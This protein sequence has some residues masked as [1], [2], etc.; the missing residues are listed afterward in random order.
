[1]MRCMTAKHEILRRILHELTYEW[2]MIMHRFLFFE[3]TEKL[4][5]SKNTTEIGRF[6]LYTLLDWAYRQKFI[7]PSIVRTMFNLTGSGEYRMM[8]GYADKGYFRKVPTSSPMAPWL[9]ILTK[10]GM[11]ILFNAWSHIDYVEEREMR[12]FIDPSK[13][14]LNGMIH[15]LATQIVTL[16][17]LLN[18]ANDY[19]TYLSERELESGGSKKLLKQPDTLVGDKNGE[20]ILA[21]E[22]ELTMKNKR[23]MDHSFASIKSIL[24]TDEA[25]FRASRVAYITQ[26]KMIYKKLEKLAKADHV[27]RWVKDKELRRWVKNGVVNMREIV[28]KDLINI[29]HYEHLKRLYP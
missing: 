20:G 6:R 5:A 27:D 2:R 24:T 28:K 12:A 19:M 3:E 29:H 21:V 1:M 7:T 9:Y 8:N 14:N 23:A 17:L 13:L 18:D 16:D 26:S 25:G 22:V 4:K 11:S 15:T 10:A